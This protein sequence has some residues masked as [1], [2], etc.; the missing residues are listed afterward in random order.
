MNDDLD[1]LRMKVVVSCWKV[2]SKR[3]IKGNG[4]GRK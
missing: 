2:Q 4:K 3:V 1:I